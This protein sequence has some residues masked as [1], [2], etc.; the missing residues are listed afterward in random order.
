MECRVA[1]WQHH[2]DFEHFRTMIRSDIW[3]GR[4]PQAPDFQFTWLRRV[5]TLHPNLTNPY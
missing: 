5:E 1:K 2:G 3:N 4:L